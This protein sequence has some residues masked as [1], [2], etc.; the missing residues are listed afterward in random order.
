M[1]GSAATV[2]GTVISLAPKATQAEGAS[3]ALGDVIMSAF[4]HGAP[5]APP[6][7][8]N[9]TGPAASVGDASRFA[10]QR[11]GWVLVGLVLGCIML[12]WV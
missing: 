9:G 5:A 12:F 8:T 1:G 4:S 6:A 11:L 2:D 10:Q 7:A 3:Q